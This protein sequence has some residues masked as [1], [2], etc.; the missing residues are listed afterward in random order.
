VLAGSMASN[1]GSAS[2]APAPRKIA[3]REIAF[4]EM[5]MSVLLLLSVEPTVRFRSVRRFD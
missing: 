3:R 4:F 1:K 2:A 5:N